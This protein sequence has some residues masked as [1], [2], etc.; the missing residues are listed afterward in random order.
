MSDL[1]AA[2]FPVF[3]SERD[4][5]PAQEYSPRG[6]LHVEPMRWPAPGD[7]PCLPASPEVAKQA[8]RDALAVVE[9]LCPTAGPAA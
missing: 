4:H 3:I 7:Q 1:L 2:C 5:V 8:I 6:A 9:E